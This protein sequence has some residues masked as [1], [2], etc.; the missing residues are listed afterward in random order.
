MKVGKAIEQL[1][2]I[3]KNTDTKLFIVG[4]FLRDYLCNKFHASNIQAKDVDLV[5]FDKDHK[6]INEMLKN[7]FRKNRVVLQKDLIETYRGN[8]NETEVDFAVIKEDFTEQR[9]M[10]HIQSFDFSCNLLALEIT[11]AKSEDYSKMITGEMTIEDIKNK[12]I[13]IS[14]REIF[15]VNI[16]EPI[17]AIMLSKKLVFS[18]NKGDGPLILTKLKQIKVDELKDSQIDE[19]ASALKTESK[20]KKDMENKINEMIQSLKGSIY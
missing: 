7:G 12:V 6:F 17:R 8:I 16:A 5:C 10:E 3:S 20:D 11:A 14:N 4:G 19:I 15:G 18:I 1:Y 2:E 9:L 13:R